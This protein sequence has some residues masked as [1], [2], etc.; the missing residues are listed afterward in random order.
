MYDKA[1]I[2]SSLIKVNKELHHK[3]RKKGCSRVPI[4]FRDN[5]DFIIGILIVKQ[6]IG[7]DLNKEITIEQL[8]VERKIRLKKPLMVE[9]SATL[10]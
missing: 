5:H 7:L 9:P 10:G 3:L 8:M 4:Y 1:F 2:I 6:L